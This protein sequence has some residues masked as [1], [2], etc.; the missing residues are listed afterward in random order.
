MDLKT[1]V[2]HHMKMSKIQTMKYFL[3][4][5]LSIS[6]SSLK[7]QTPELSTKHLTTWKLQG[8]TD[9][10][11]KH[12]LVRI[13]DFCNG[14]EIIDP[15]PQ[16]TFREGF[17]DVNKAALKTNESLANTLIESEILTTLKAGIYIRSEKSRH[18]ENGKSVKSLETNTRLTF[19]DHRLMLD[20]KQSQRGWSCFYERTISKK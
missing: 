18:F 10:C 3:P 11:P 14:F 13:S 1:I 6:C 7:A 2:L 9:E 19:Q 16:S 5:L 17:C 4:A 20:R 15:R 8:G 12:L